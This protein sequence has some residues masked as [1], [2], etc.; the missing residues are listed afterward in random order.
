M[1]ADHTPSPEPVLDEN[2][3][4]FVGSPRLIRHD[5][6]YVGRQ[7]ERIVSA[8]NVEFGEK[9]AA[10]F[11]QSGDTGPKNPNSSGRKRVNGKRRSGRLSEPV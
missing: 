5:V 9:I 11:A 6:E 2:L 10:G 3:R 4:R 8:A 7:I 1:P